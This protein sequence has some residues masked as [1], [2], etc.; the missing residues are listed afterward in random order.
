MDKHKA[1][2][3]LKSGLDVLVQALGDGLVEVSEDLHR[4]LRVD[5]RAADQVVERIG[6][7]KPDARIS[8]SVLAHDAQA[9]ACKRS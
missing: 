2:L 3:E 9:T 5:A 4:Q 7:R 1:H 6:Q 8:E